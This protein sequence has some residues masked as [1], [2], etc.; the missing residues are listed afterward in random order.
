[1]EPPSGNPALIEAIREKIAATT[2][3]AI[4]FDEFMQLAL[5]HPQHGY[6]SSGASQRVGRA[7]DFFTSVSVGECF[8]KLL[9]AHFLKAQPE[10][11]QIVE[12]GANDGQLASDLLDHLPEGIDYVIIEPF[13]AVRA[14][15]QKKLGDRATWV[16]SID[17]IPGGIR[18]HFI[19]NELLDAFPVKRVRLENHQ[20][21]EVHIGADF[22]EVTTAITDTELLE[23]IQTNLA[24]RDPPEGYTT[25]LHLEANTWTRQLIDHLQPGAHATIIDYGHVADDYYSPQRNDGTLR[26]FR[27]HQQVTN[28]F[29]HI[30]ETDLTASV[31]FTRIAEIAGTENQATDQ[32]HFLIDAARPWLAEIEATGTAPDTAAQALLRQFNTLI[33]PAMMGRSF[34]VLQ[35][36]G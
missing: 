24:H 1:M 26:G 9:A 19:C 2:A 7:G 18:G 34:K 30:G 5:Y 23:E 16:D 31:N 8:G 3:G 15:Q 32:H 17:Q 4:P 28:F 36:R 10:L 22:E 12:Q 29:E 35:L 14:Q 20:W 6:Y 13:P 25:E 11:N 33:H 21:Q 27:N